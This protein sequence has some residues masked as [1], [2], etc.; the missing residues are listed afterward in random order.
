LFKSKSDIPERYLF[1]PST[2]TSIQKIVN[3]IPDSSAVLDVGCCTGYLAKML[4][5]KKCKVVGVEF[6]QNA[7]NIAKEFCEDVIIADI[8]AVGSL[9]YPKAYFDVI[10]YADI[11]EH[12][13]RPDLVLKKFDPYLKKNGL[14]IM[15][16]PNIA[17]IEMRLTLLFGNFNYTEIGLLDKTHLRFFTFKTAK[18]L[19]SNAGYRIKKVEYT[20]LASRFCFLKYMPNLFS[21]QF[22]FITTR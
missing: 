5:K 19:I 20:G 10:V 2:H 11:L 15:S 4:E 8:E 18:Q 22:V 12:L 1:N 9:P 17:R 16:L 14:C 21:Y 7:G 3:S 6:D 13:R